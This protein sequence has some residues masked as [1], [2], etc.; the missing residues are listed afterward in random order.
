MGNKIF[1]ALGLSDLKSYLLKYFLPIVLMDFFVLFIFVFAF[2]STLLR[3]LG[4]FI[5]F[6]VLAV[7]FLY[8][9]ML[10]DNQSKAIEE[11]I[12]YFITYAGALSTVN[13]D[14]KDFFADLSEK[15]RYKEISNVFKRLIYL[16]ESIKVDFSTASYKLASIIKTEHFSRFLERMGITLSFGS[17]ISKFFVDEQKVLMDAYSIVYKEGLERIRVVQ[18][19]FTSLIL[20]FAFVLATILLIPFLSGSDPSLYLLF[21]LVGVIMLDSVLLVFANYFIPTDN[22]YHKMGLDEGRQKV[23]LFLLISITVS[24][25][26]M[27]FILFTGLPAIVKIAIICTPLLLVGIYSNMQEKQVWKRDSLFPAFVRSLGD[28]HQ[29]KGGTLT[30]TIETL[31]PHNFGILNPMIEKVFKRLKITSD[32]LSSWYYFTRESGSYLIAE[33]MDIFVSVVY[34]GGSSLVAGRIVSDNMTRING[35]RDMKKEFSSTLKGAI[36]GS[37]FGLAL[38]LYISLL[39]SVLLLRIFTSLTGDVDASSLALVGDIFPTPSTD[40]AP[41][42][43]ANTFIAFILAVHAF[44]SAYIIK[45]VDGGNPMSMFSDVVYL[46]WFGVAIETVTTFLFEAMFS[47]YFG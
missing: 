13:L 18:E 30:T 3:L 8:P 38:T 33:F 46:L 40:T 37:F 7:V 5:F 25:L 36:Y 45:K 4:V 22:L 35:L 21:G 42:D 12:H 14:R 34:R 6:S 11:S 44:F 28:V 20:A 29:A 32:K 16:V 1:A 27:P 17:D 19:M 2:Q 43:T 39:I 47:S 23:L 15:N 9:M 26:I 31:L 10:I 41:T 24:I